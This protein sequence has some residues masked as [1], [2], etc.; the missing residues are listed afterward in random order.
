M[1]GTSKMTLTTLDFSVLEA[2]EFEPAC[3]YKDGG[4]SA[5][6]VFDFRGTYLCSGAFI[7]KFICDE[8]HNFLIHYCGPWSCNSCDHRHF[9]E[10][11]EMFGFYQWTTL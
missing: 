3:E 10:H 6:A 4:C 11:R 1:I 8:H 9:G 7:H 2:L 5:T